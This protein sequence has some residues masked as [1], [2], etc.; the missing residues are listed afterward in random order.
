MTSRKHKAMVT[1]YYGLVRPSDWEPSVVGTDRSQ[2]TSNL[3]VAVHN[4]SSVT[5]RYA[6]LS[7]SSIEA[8]K[9]L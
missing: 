3:S 1:M 4:V 7:N 5:D 8:G 9:L 6:P 2:H